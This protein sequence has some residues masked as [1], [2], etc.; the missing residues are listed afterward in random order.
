MG[1]EVL[2]SFPININVVNKKL[3]SIWKG[4]FRVIETNGNILKVQAS[5]RSKIIT[6]HVNRVQLFHHFKDIVTTEIEPTSDTP[7]TQD[8]EEE[9]EEEDEDDDGEVVN[10]R[11]VRF[12]EQPEE[13]PELQVPQ[14]AEADQRVVPPI[15]LQ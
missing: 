12:E 1:D 2:V 10:T 15:R 14:R 13:I 9:E 7:M 5:P 6:L 11:Q 4:P 3:S 8:I